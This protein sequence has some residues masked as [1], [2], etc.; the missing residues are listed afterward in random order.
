[1]KPATNDY[2]AFK[3][4]MERLLSAKGMPL[5]SPGSLARIG[6]YWR[7]SMGTDAEFERA[8]TLAIR[9]IDPFPS[10]AQL[11]RLMWEQ[12]RA[13]R[14]PEANTQAA[15]RCSACGGVPWWTMRDGEWSRIAVRHHDTAPCA[16]YNP[17][18]VTWGEEV[19]L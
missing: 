6:A 2:S 9:T 1:M 17:P 12:R 13:E 19:A 15:L 10:I 14:R 18:D 8:V 7:E 16:R 5:D 4:Q 3:F 11:D